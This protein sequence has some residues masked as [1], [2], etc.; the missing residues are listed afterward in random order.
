MKYF[1]S[2]F[3]FFSSFSSV[4]TYGA[5]KQQTYQVTLY[6]SPQCPYSQ[7]VLSYLKKAGIKIPLK[8]VKTDSTARDELL[9]IGGYLVVPCLIINGNP[10]Y[11]A[12]DII[13]WLSAHQEDL[14]KL[15]T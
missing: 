10:I 12:N 6:Y 4:Q 13:D 2:F 11:N 1:L 5:L 8:N 15:S 9:E 14:S 3:L 7:K